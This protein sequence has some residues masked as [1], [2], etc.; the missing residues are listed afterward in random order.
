MTRLP[1]PLP[2]TLPSEL[3]IFLATLPPEPMVRMLALSQSTAK[4]FI[5]FARTLFTAL[6]LP[7][8]SRELVILTVAAHTD[9]V[10]VAAQHQALAAAAGVESTVRELITACEFGSA[11][12]S[13]NDRIIIRFAAEAVRSP[14][15]SDSVF[16]DARRLLGDRQMVEVLHVVGYYWTFGRISTTLDVDVTRVYGGDPL[17]GIPAT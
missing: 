15:V 7:A 11:E 17:L 12:L 2:A 1:Q 16:A 6:E 8:R 14:R 3:N 9:A 13:E 5:Q 4:S 10:F